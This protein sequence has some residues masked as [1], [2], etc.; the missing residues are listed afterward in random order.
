METS[1]GDIN[2]ITEAVRGCNSMDSYIFIK[3]EIVVG[4]EST[5]NTEWIEHVPERTH[6]MD[7]TNWSKWQDQIGKGERPWV[8]KW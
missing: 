8:G 6:R 1:H 2:S 5:D 4:G 7:R 3:E